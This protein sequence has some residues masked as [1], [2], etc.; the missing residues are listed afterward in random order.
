MFLKIFLDMLVVIKRSE[1]K[2]EWR[3]ESKE[4]V[5]QNI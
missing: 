5:Q 1:F 2:C 3:K 4:D